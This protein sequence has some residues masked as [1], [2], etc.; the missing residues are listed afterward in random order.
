MPKKLGVTYNRVI[1]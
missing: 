1:K